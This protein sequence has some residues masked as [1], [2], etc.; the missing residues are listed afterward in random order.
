VNGLTLCVI[1]AAKEAACNALEVADDLDLSCPS[2]LI[3]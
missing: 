2:D 3:P 1:A